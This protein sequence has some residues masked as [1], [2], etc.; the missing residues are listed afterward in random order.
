MNTLTTNIIRNVYNIGTNSCDAGIQY[1]TDGY[2]LYFPCLKDITKGQEVC[3]DFYV[4][5]YAG[6]NAKDIEAALNSDDTDSGSGKE[7]VDLRDV[8]AISLNLIGA[9]NCQYGTFSYPDNISSLQTEDY[10][11]VYHND[12]GNRTPCALKIFMIDSKSNSIINAIGDDEP[13]YFYS[14]TEVEISALDT[15]TH[16]FVGWDFMDIDDEGCQED[17]WYDHIS[18]TSSTYRFTI[19]KDTTIIAV[20]RPRK[21]YDIVSD[22]TNKFSHFNVNYNHTSYY[23][24]NRP[25][26]IFNDAFDVLENVLEGY[27]M[28][29]KCIPSVDIYDS[30]SDSENDMTYVFDHWKDGNTNRCRLFTIGVDTSVFEEE[31]TIKLK[32]F[33][34]G[35]VPYYEQEDE[36]I[37]Y[38]D[39]FDE[40]GIHIN[41]ESSDVDIVDFYGDGQYIKS[42]EDVYLKY[43]DEEGFLY[44]N[45][46]N[47]VLSSFGIEDGIKIDIHAKADDYCEIHI[48]V[49]GYE[50]N[51]E[52]SQEEFKLYEFYFHKCDKKD[53]EITVSGECLI[54]LIDVY[55]EKII[56]KGKARLCLGPDITSNL[57]SGKLSVNGAIMVN[58]KSYGLATTTIG[59][60]NRLPSIIINN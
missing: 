45:G 52:I 34:T 39:E 16:I 33:C 28:V 31:E 25:D 42:T 9:F 1:C 18:N 30:E 53:I 8:D 27:H 6:K 17:T 10:T 40:E 55:K 50:I 46:G 13:E 29:V 56:D 22:L 43:I 37:L 57:P 11:P 7:L 35:P 59:N 15:P 20:Y 48:A 23:I 38:N 44:F 5:D 51:Q 24:S 14:G 60:V 2:A 21:K 49:N 47:M 3:F 32:A 36:D 58:G 4:A 26:E 54:D 19:K 41:T 12:F